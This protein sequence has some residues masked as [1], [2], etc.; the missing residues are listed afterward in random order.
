MDPPKKEKC[1][2][3]GV[4]RFTL[5]AMEPCLTESTLHSWSNK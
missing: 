4:K 1:S 5:E 2:V 3:C